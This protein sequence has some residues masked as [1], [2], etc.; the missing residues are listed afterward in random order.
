MPEHFRRNAV[1]YLALFVALGGT[2]YAA[3][4]LPAG[5]VGTK[6]L[7]K[8]AVTKAKLHNNAV[9][10]PQVKNGSLKALDFA[11]GQIPAGAKGDRGLT[12]LTGPI[13]PTLGVSGLT[14]GCCPS[15]TPSAAATVRSSK[16][17][18]LPTPARLF[19]IASTEVSIT[20]A[21]G[22]CLTTWGLRVDGVA[23]PG[24][25]RTAQH[26]QAA[27]G[28]YGDRHESLTL[29]GVTGVLAP[30]PHTISIVA[31]GFESG[32]DQQQIGAIALGT[33]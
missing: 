30:G 1:A 20:C 24:S 25:G 21:A 26:T 12:G 9:T 14:T 3:I 23:V 4:K 2:S 27:Q 11:P 6:H 18:N 7:K 32:Y 22:V 8:G 13:G 33:G 31:E 29:F 19:V 10:S 5:S 15:P 28:I 16:V 17:V